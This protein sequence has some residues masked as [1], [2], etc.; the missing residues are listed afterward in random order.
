MFVGTT[1]NLL[2]QQQVT[3]TSCT[4]HRSH[5]KGIILGLLQCVGLHRDPPEPEIDFLRLGPPNLQLGLSSDQS[6]EARKIRHGEIFFA[7]VAAVVIQASLIAIA[8]VTVF[9]DP[10]RKA[11]PSEP[12]AYGFPCYVAGSILLSIGIG[13]CSYVVERNTV[14]YTWWVVPK[15]RSD[16]EVGVSKPAELDKDNDDEMKAM[17]RLMWL[18]QDQ[19]VSD[20]KFGGYAIL[21][22][23]KQHITTSSR[24]EDTRVLEVSKSLR[25]SSD[26]VPNSSMIAKK[27]SNDCRRSYVC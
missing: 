16:V 14:E 21:A 22:G 11:M 7:G 13:T 5:S 3:L 1:L 2:L 18:Q 4:D 25:E 26:I 24:L 12:K 20:Q 6:A 10:I 15:T 23:A 19:E 17:P 27:V 9:Y 8:S